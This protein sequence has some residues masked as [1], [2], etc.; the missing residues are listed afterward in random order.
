MI[1][2]AVDH[3]LHTSARTADPSTPC[4]VAS[5]PRGWPE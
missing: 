1:L 3:L 4:P 5:T 2:K